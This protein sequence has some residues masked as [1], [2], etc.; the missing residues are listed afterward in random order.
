MKEKLKDILAVILVL[1]VIA[2]WATVGFGWPRVYL[3]L[4]VICGGLLI[5]VISLMHRK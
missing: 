5:G 2:I 3:S 1:L 4:E